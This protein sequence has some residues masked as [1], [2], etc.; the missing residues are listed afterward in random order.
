LNRSIVP[1]K[2]QKIRGNSDV[3]FLFYSV[4]DDNW[5]EVK[6][7]LALQYADQRDLGTLEHQ[8]S[9]MTQG[10]STL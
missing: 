6:R 8:L 4:Q 2:R 5:W 1:H 10:N 7:D 3:A 9:Q